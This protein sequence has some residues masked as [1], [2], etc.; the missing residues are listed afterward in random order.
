MTLQ[1]V[2]DLVLKFNAHGSEGL[3][4]HNPSARPRGASTSIVS[5]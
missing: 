5:I 2:Q 1:I 3:I 4:D